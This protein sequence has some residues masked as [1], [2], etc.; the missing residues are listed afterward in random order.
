MNE[1]FAIL[2]MMN[3]YFHDVATALLVASA[4]V[5]WALMKRLPVDPAVEAIQYFVKVYHLITR[6]ALFSL[7][8]IIVGGIPRTIFYKDF[9]WSH[10]A[11]QGQVP[12]LVVKHVLAFALVFAGVA[13]WSRA[14]K[15]VAVLK[16]SLGA[17]Q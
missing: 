15:R 5:M 8:W 4:V 3:N 7:A 14:K 9:E 16:D 6:F 10:M 11:G 2:L 1:S 12:A 17:Q 13:L